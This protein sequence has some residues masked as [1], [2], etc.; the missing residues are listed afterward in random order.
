MN[1]KDE[2]SCAGVASVAA[3]K[4]KEGKELL[5]KINFFQ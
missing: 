2:P 1:N 3:P 4:E 5:K